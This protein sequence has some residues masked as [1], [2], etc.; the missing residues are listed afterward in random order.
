MQIASLAAY[1][2]AVIP[3][4]AAAPATNAPTAK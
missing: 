2:N 4:H 1:L 3:P